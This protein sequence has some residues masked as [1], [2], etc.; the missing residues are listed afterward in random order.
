LGSVPTEIEK[1]AGVEAFAEFSF[2]NQVN[3]LAGGDILK[4]RAIMNLPYD[5]FFIKMR[6]NKV[7]AAFNKKY[8]ELS[9]KE[10]QK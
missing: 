2:Y 1:R 9:L 10:N 5:E 6:M 3:A 8:Q 4:W 7:E